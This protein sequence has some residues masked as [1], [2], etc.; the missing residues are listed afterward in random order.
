MGRL[1]FTLCVTLYWY[2]VVVS[3]LPIYAVIYLAPE[4][5]RRVTPLVLLWFTVLAGP[6]AWATLLQTNY[7]LSYVACER[8]QPWLL[9]LAAAIAL[10]VV[11][12]GGGDAWRVLRSLRH[13]HMQVAQGLLAT[14][15]PVLIL[16]PCT[17]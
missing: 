4:S 10:F 17:P 3:W 2:F 13:D 5:S 14:E 15:I 1:Q 16:H 9:H 7:V 11:G 8:Q 12:V 6:L